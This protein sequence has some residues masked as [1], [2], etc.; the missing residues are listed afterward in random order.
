MHVVAFIS[1]PMVVNGNQLNS[2]ED[3]WVNNANSVKIDLAT[4]IDG[5]ESD[6]EAVKEVARYSVD[7]A[8]ISAPVKGI[9]IVKMSDGTTRKVMIAE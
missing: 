3:M 8:R 7:G 2:Y 4:G 5:V 6:G 9:N 1:R